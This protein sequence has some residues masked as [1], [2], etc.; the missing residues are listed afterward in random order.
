M[1]GYA[2]YYVLTNDELDK[3]VWDYLG[4]HYESDIVNNLYGQSCYE[5]PVLAAC[6]VH[7]DEKSP[8]GDVLETLLFLE[9]IPMSDVYL[10]K[11]P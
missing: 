2:T 1:A 6:C 4:V 7:I 10:I 3:L 11:C 8:I 5:Y 9:I